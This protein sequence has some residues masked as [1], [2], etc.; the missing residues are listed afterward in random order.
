MITKNGVKKRT[1]A[2]IGIGV[3][4]LL[5]VMAVMLLLSFAMLSLLSAHSDSILS[6]KAAQAIKD[7]Y[8]ADCQAEMWWMKLNQTVK[9]TD[10]TLVSER[11]SAGGFEAE[12]LEGNY[13]VRNAFFMGDNK[14][15][16]VC[17]EISESGEIRILLWQSMPAYRPSQ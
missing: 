5:T 2:A 17:A 8:I 1:S 15:L 13:I 3:T 16:L 9:N 7:Y 12:F 6:E 4:T 14:N 10:E 11:L